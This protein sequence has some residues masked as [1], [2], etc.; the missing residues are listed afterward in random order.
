M[1]LLACGWPES[2]QTC[3]PLRTSM[4]CWRLTA[5]GL[6]L[7]GV[8]QGH[9]PA[10]CR[11]PHS[12]RESPGRGSWWGNLGV[13]GLGPQACPVLQTLPAAQADH[14]GILP[15]ASQPSLVWPASAKWPI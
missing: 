2:P 1:R 10:C 4:S 3:T 9:G 13:G 15:G 14:G 6:S 5:L 7:G 11:G 8:T 12:W